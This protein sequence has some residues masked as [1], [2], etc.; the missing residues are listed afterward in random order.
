MI[1]IGPMMPRQLAPSPLCCHGSNLAISRSGPQLAPAPRRS[2]TTLVR[3]LWHTRTA[4]GCNIVAGS[5]S[6]ERGAQASRSNLH[7]LAV[8]R[9]WR[10]QFGKYTTMPARRQIVT[11][12]AVWFAIASGARPE[13]H[14]PLPVGSPT[15]RP[16]ASTNSSASSSGNLLA[17]ITARQRKSPVYTG[18]TM[19]DNRGRDFTT[20]TGQAPP[21]QS[22]VVPHQLA[23]CPISV[24][25]VS[26]E[27]LSYGSTGYIAA[28]RSWYAFFAPNAMLRSYNMDSTANAGPIQFTTLRT[29]KEA[30]WFPRQ[31]T[32]RARTGIRQN[33]ECA[34]NVRKHGGYDTGNWADC[35][36]GP[37][38]NANYAT[39]SHVGIATTL[40]TKSPCHSVNTGPFVTTSFASRPPDFGF[41]RP[42]HSDACAVIATTRSCGRCAGACG[43]P[44][45]GRI[46]ADSKRPTISG[47]WRCEW[48]CQP[49]YR[50]RK[51]MPGCK[52]ASTPPPVANAFS[53]T[54]R[55]SCLQSSKNCLWPCCGGPTVSSSHALSTHKSQQM[56]GSVIV[57]EERARGSKDPWAGRCP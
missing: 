56:E 44:D 52:L 23:P 36:C 38:A 16:T 21:N 9:L 24:Q 33:S 11:L 48:H 40:A 6:R 22:E 27:I 50:G 14:A 18:V 5:A 12:V 39:P 10:K 42:N 3:P 30:R 29:W 15:P 19:S 32:L 26:F 57:A 1:H 2:Q 35:D 46:Q 54:S 45:G 43:A 37:S 53:T 51:G 41:A 34:R 28:T 31:G 20:S 49:L 7:V 4:E 55:L 13:S 47:F 25:G 17:G 8:P